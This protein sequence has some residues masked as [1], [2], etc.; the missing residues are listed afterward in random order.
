MS[1]FA[2]EPIAVVGVSAIM[3]DAPDASAF[4]D[5]IRGGRYCISDVPPDRWDPERYYDPDP[6]AP[7]KTYSRI[8]GWVREFPWDPIGWRLP[9]PPR[10]ADQLDDGQKWA[11]AGSREALLD[12]GWPDWEVDT[13]RVRSEERRVG[14]E[15]RSRWSP[16]H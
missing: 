1:N 6:R 12:A 13:D 10:V 3:P 16:D 2:P 8:G 15:C 4:W 11:V 14:K 7:Y 5:N 9:V